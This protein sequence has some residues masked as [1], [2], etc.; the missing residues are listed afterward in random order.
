M[1]EVWLAAPAPAVSMWREAAQVRWRLNDAACAWSRAHGLSDAAWAEFARSL[2][3]GAAQRGRGEVGEVAVG[4]TACALGPGRLVWLVP[5]RQPSP[6]ASPAFGS[7]SDRLE[8]LQEFGRI[9]MFERHIGSGEGH[10]DHH[11]F[12]L[13]GIDPAGGLPTFA[14]AM[15]R[16]HPEDRADILAWNRKF[17]EEPGRHEVRY[18]LLLPDGQVR[19]IHSQLELRT[20]PDGKP[21]TVFGVVIDDTESAARLR[22]QEALSANLARAIDLAG[23]SVWHHDLAQGSFQFNATGYRAMGMPPDSGG[24]GVEDVR[25]TL[26]PDDRAAVVRAADEAMQRH[27]AVD[28]VARYS[29]PDGGWRHWLTRRV[30]ERDERGRVVAMAGVSI[31]QTEQVAER[32]RA[33][34]LSRRIDMVA[35]VAGL[36]VWSIEIDSGRVEWNAQMFELHGLAVADR[37][38]TPR[39]WISTLVHRDDRRRL[40]AQ[41]R[42]SVAAGEVGFDVDFRIVRPDGAVRWIVSRARRELRDGRPCLVGIHLDVSERR[43]TEAELQ[44][45]Q[46]RLAVATRAAGAGIWEREVSGAWIYW[47]EQ[48]YRLRG[49]GPDDPRSIDEVIRATLDRAQRIDLRQLFIDHV[50]AGVPYERELRLVWPDGSVH[51]V[52]TAGQ[53]QRDESGR[54]LRVVGVN[55]DI[56]Q[57]KLAESALRDKE[58]A[59]RA[60]RAK[61]EFLA[62]MSHELRTPLN[63]VIGFAQLI[64]REG[65]AQLGPV[66]RER[67]ER[68]R[69]AGAHLLAL[70]EDVLD[71]ASIESA[72]LPIALEPVALGAALE[73]VREWVQP[74]AE[75]AGVTLHLPR[76]GPWIVADA[77]R[78]RQVL[79]NL[80]TNAIKYNRAGGSVWIEARTRRSADAHE[81]MTC[82][83]VRDDGRG[84]STVQVAHL[85]EP[86]NRLGAEREPIEGVGIGLMIVRHLVQFMGGRVEVSS[87][88]GQGSEFRLWLPA[89]SGAPPQ[90]GTAL[91]PAASPQGAAPAGLSVLYIEDNPVNVLLVEEMVALRGNVTLRCAVDGASGLAE[92]LAWRPDVVL[93]DMQLPDMDG[94]EVLRRLRAQPALADAALVA[95]SANAMPED[96]A[97]AREAGFDDY[98]TKPIDVERFLAG[99]DALGA[100]QGARRSRSQ[101]P[102][103]SR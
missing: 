100:A 77:R 12:R 31:D 9:G 42:R 82:I 15:E 96:V 11:M 45:Q 37:A 34:A 49:L 78:L 70:I 2:L 35:A 71:M 103:S 17:A 28:V 97:R 84:M 48:M 101:D 54:P 79:A 62:R 51:W 75:R 1:D 66:Q 60:S 86:F 16:V 102:A 90:P 74:I 41:L 53:V 6:E 65:G 47:S 36:G 23:V 69:S 21:A 44:R 29:K 22:A 40:S 7:A 88:P 93:V 46:E 52:A 38:P 99:L 64:E 33:Q 98:W 91:P 32:E 55:W 76:E 24:V 5:E 26:H 56:T 94:F 58:T 20:G 61:S 59:E 13:F 19:E 18:R 73:D 72:T 27:D 57:R 4:W 68:I 95:L 8:M 43:A 89:A 39:Q 83:A 67:V 14:A 50:N 30:A 85:F 25:A 81:S 10:W 87:T 92:A 3:D 63:A 80:L